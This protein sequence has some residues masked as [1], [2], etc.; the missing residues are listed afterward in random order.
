[1]STLGSSIQKRHG[2]TGKSP[3]KGNEYG[4]GTG[5]FVIGGEAKQTRI[6][7]PQEGKTWG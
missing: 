1:M 5:V 6:I 4:K 2:H 7:Q 3:V